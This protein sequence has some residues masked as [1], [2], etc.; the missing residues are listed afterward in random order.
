MSDMV[1][2]RAVIAPVQVA[3]PRSP[4]TVYRENLREARARALEAIWNDDLPP[5]QRIDGEFTSILGNTTSTSLLRSRDRS[6][7]GSRSRPAS[8]AGLHG[9]RGRTMAWHSEQSEKGRI[10]TMTGASVSA[11]SK[12]TSAE[13]FVLRRHARATPPTRLNTASAKISGLAATSSVRKDML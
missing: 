5:S 11:F 3:T 8:S 12:W 1:N 9:Q 6:A 4:R 10:W 7:N 2:P 13:L